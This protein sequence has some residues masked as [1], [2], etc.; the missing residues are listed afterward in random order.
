MTTNAPRLLA[1]VAEYYDDKARTYG[2]TPKGADW[3]DAESQELRFLELAKVLRG[4]RTGSIAEVGCGWGAFPLWAQRHS[5]DLDYTG[6]DIS[7]V[8]L[9]EAES[10]CGALPNVRF[11]KGDRPDAMADYVV[12][13]GIFNVRFDAPND[14]WLDLVRSTIDN[15]YEKARI[16]IAF[17][18]LTGFSDRDRMEAR[19][20]YADPG[21][22]LNYCIGRFGRH[23]TLNHDYGLY[24][25]TVLVWKGNA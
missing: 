7:E 18:F 23:V 10:V 21:A 25:F 12:A 14:N 1:Q 8:M 4:A 20:Y 3:R 13:S 5:L 17:N 15:M 2:A 11:A 24:E 6:Y 22:I 19:L 9:R 16:G